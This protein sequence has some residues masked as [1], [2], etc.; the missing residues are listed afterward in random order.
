MYKKIKLNGKENQGKVKIVIMYFNYF[1]VKP[2]SDQEIDSQ[3]LLFNINIYII[4]LILRLNVKIECH[5][6]IFG[7]CVIKLTYSKNE[8]HRLFLCFAKVVDKVLH[9]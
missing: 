6:K 1:M 2:I 8:L 4:R 9:P 5:I 3:V 7:N